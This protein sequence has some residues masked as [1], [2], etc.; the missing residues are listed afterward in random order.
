MKKYNWKTVKLTEHKH[1]MSEMWFYNVAKKMGFDFDHSINMFDGGPVPGFCYRLKNTCIYIQSI[2]GNVSLRFEGNFYLFDKDHKSFRIDW[3]GHALYQDIIYSDEES[4]DKYM[5]EYILS[6]KEFEECI[7][8][9]LQ[10]FKNEMKESIKN[11]SD[12]ISSLIDN[13]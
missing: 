3:K 5:E 12:L 13:Y 4:R 8:E 2:F 9:Y 6:D 11:Y 10:F 1:S 7:N